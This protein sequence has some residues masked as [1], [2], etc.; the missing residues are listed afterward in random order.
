MFQ[1]PTVYAKNFGMLLVFRFLTDFFGSPALAT[2]GATIADMYRPQKQAYGLTVWGI[3]AVCGPV[4]GPL[5]GGFAVQANLTN[6]APLRGWQWTI[7]ELMWLSGFC[8][9]MLFVFLPETSSPN[10]LH[11]RTER[12]RKL[13]GDERLTCEP[14]MAAEQM[15]PRDVSLFALSITHSLIM[16]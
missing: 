7:W 11:R 5:V 15:G 6:S 12:L 1:F 14:D 16:S 8:L 9:I 3:G 10:I 2:G 13:T 4:L